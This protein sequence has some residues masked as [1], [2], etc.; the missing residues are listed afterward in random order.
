[1]N[2]IKLFSKRS[3]VGGWF[4]FV[5]ALLLIGLIVR[6]S[7]FNTPDHTVTPLSQY[8]IRE[9]V[10]EEVD[11]GETTTYQTIMYFKVMSNERT[12]E[13]RSSRYECSELLLHITDKSVIKFWLHPSIDDWVGQLVVD[14]RM[15]V[16]HSDSYTQAWRRRINF[17]WVAGS[18][19][20]LLLYYAFI[21]QFKKKRVGLRSGS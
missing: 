11:C 3:S 4:A 15:I 8:S 9:G 10:V 20:I 21:G 13:V 18:I 7:F 14:G 16:P 6:G 19:S 1:M 17:A 12:F 5:F 2:K